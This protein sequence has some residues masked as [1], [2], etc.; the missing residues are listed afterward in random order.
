MCAPETE[1]SKAHDYR[2]P[3]QR[4]REA[5]VEQ[6]SLRNPMLRD[7]D[8]KDKFSLGG[9]EG[10]QGAQRSPLRPRPP[11]GRPSTGHCQYPNCKGGVMDFGLCAIHYQEYSRHRMK[12]E[13]RAYNPNAKNPMAVINAARSCF[14]CLSCVLYCAP[15]ASAASVSLMVLY[16]ARLCSYVFVP[17]SCCSDKNHS[18]PLNHTTATPHAATRETPRAGLPTQETALTPWPGLIRIRVNRFQILRNRPV[19]WP[20]QQASSIFSSK[21]TQKCDWLRVSQQVVSAEAASNAMQGTLLWLRPGG[22]AGRG[23]WA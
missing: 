18:N 7:R 2:S 9:G 12:P 10:G 8:R 15:S 23:P 19:V 22:P 20:S 3:I 16:F 17:L 14:S 1:S 21:W 6:A 11:P 13:D 4:I 5:G